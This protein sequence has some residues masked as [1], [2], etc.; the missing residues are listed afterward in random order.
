MMSE[1]TRDRIV[2][3][4]AKDQRWNAAQV[5][6]VPKAELD[7]EGCAFYAAV[8]EDRAAP[9]PGYFGLLPDGRVAGIDL[10]G[11]DAAAVL[12]ASCGR[13]APADWWATVVARFSGSIGGSVLTQEG[14]PYGIRRVRERGAT[15]APPALTRSPAGAEL[16]FFSYDAELK[17]PYQVRAMLS[18]DGKLKVESRAL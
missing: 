7:R 18:P 14:N 15:F 2:A 1:A 9:A 16:A 3:A 17:Q 8:A 13:D 10:R 5:K 11:D 6:L 4:A 12:L